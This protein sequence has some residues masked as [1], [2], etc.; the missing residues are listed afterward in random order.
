MAWPD[1]AG[2]GQGLALATSVLDGGAA[3]RKF[4]AICAAQG[5]MRTPPRARY[6]EVLGAAHGGRV[7]AIDNASVA[8]VAT[9]AGA[10]AAPAAGLEL[11]VR[12]G[13]AVAAGQPLLT[14]HAQSP[15]EL[16]Y[17]V[18]YAQSQSQAQ[19]VTIARDRS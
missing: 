10:P 17:A 11:H 7:V 16:A 19:P 9:L 3:W 1:K 2:A 6:T 15:G 12:L 13:S 5:G 14:V 4:Q 18:A 8:R